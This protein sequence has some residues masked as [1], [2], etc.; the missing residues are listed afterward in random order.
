MKKDT[1]R[2]VRLSI[3]LTAD[4]AELIK[5]YARTNG[6]TVSYLVS[7]MISDFVQPYKSIFHDKVSLTDSIMAL[8]SKLDDVE[9]NINE[10]MSFINN[11]VNENMSLKDRIDNG[12]SR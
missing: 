6:T 3:S 10:N 1:S 12:N 5:K 7:S 9:Q 11:L 8:Y 2:N 4:D